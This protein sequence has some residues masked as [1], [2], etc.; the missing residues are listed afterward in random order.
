MLQ[1]VIASLEND[2]RHIWHIRLS[3]KILNYVYHDLKE[4][5][6][7]VHLQW[8]SALIYVP[9][10]APERLKCYM[11]ALWCRA[12][13]V[14]VCVRRFSSTCI[15]YDTCDVWL[16]PISCN[17]VSGVLLQSTTVHGKNEFLGHCSAPMYLGLTSYWLYPGA[18]PLHVILNVNCHPSASYLVQPMEPCVPPPRKWVPLL[19][20][21]QLGDTAPWPVVVS[22]KACSSSLHFVQQFLVSHCM[23]IPG[24]TDIPVL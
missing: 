6:E 17:R 20:W 12:C 14:L 21:V 16:A 19:Q 5:A 7:L 18:N 22:H 1:K 8:W 3:I 24:S 4:L 15:V 23:R 2:V 13:L 11:H 10:K 9:L